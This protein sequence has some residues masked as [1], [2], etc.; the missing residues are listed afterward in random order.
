MLKRRF[1][2][3]GETLRTNKDTV[4]VMVR[5]NKAVMTNI[6]LEEPNIDAGVQGDVHM[7]NIERQEN[8]AIQGRL[9]RAQII[10]QYF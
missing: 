4:A 8:A 10:R 6:D 3:L 2:Y 5:H 9:K 1:C 7:D